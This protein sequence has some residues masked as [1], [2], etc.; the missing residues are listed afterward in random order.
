MNIN[1]DSL[2]FCQKQKRERIFQKEEIFSIHEKISEILKKFPNADYIFYNPWAVCTSYQYFP[3]GT[4][5]FYDR[6]TKAIQFTRG[7]CSR[8]SW[9]KAPKNVYRVHIMLPKGEKPV[10]GKVFSRVN[11]YE[12][13]Y[14][15]ISL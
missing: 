11:D 6:G 8:T 3:M 5:A 12:R 7:K 2:Y 1:L 9:G 13:D 14:L 4:I 10:M 15:K